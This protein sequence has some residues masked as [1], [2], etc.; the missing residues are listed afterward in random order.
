LS[1]YLIKIDLNIRINI[2]I[3]KMDEDYPEI[4]IDKDV[5]EPR[6]LSSSSDTLI[7]FPILPKIFYKSLGLMLFFLAGTVVCASLAIYDIHPKLCMF[8][9]ASLLFITFISLI[10]NAFCGWSY[11]IYLKNEITEQVN[12][13]V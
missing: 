2:K 3:N 10:I 12:G 9:G 1:N 6:R 11:Y 8:L 7:N 5:V 13:I 4:T